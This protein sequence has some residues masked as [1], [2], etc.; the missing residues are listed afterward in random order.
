V[1]FGGRENRLSKSLTDRELNTGGWVTAA[2][3]VFRTCT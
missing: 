1:R 2:G 3:V